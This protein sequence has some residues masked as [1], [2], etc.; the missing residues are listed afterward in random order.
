MKKGRV[1]ADFS[2]RVNSIWKK[3]EKE[4]GRPYSFAKVS[5][6]KIREKDTN[7]VYKYC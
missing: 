4:E 7:C 3:F 1:S 5:E 2:K 6:Q